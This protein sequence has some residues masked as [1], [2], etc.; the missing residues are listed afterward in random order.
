MLLIFLIIHIIINIIFI[1]SIYHFYNYYYSPYYSYHF[2]EIKLGSER[3][4]VFVP[5]GEMKSRMI[6]N[7]YE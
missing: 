3:S 6:S 7:E 1:N 5:N 4:R 2:H